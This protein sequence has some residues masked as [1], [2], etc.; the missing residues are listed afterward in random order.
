MIVQNKNEL[1]QNLFRT[2][3]IVKWYWIPILKCDIFQTD[4]KKSKKSELSLLY[5][6]WLLHQENIT[7]VETDY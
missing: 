5:V 7:S 2:I 6:K 4:G 1:Q 3:E